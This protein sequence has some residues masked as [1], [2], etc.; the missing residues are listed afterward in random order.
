MAFGD[1]G[2]AL[3]ILAVPAALFLGQQWMVYAPVGA[4]SLKAR[5]RRD[6]N[7]NK[8]NQIS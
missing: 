3:G 4:Q 5:T 2:S 1:T 7:E 6:S 8:E